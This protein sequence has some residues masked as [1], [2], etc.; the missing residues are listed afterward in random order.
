MWPGKIYVTG[1]FGD[2]KIDASSSIHSSIECYDP[3]NDEWEKVGDL[4]VPRGH[5]VSTAYKSKDSLRLRHIST[6]S[7]E[8]FIIDFKC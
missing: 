4:L 1:G 3:P 6:Y 5:H 7:I 2:D 8:S